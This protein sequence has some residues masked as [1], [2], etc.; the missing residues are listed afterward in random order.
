M[1]MSSGARMG[2][3]SS[4]RRLAGRSGHLHSRFRVCGAHRRIPLVRSI[5][6]DRGD[7]QQRDV[8]TPQCARYSR[9]VLP[10]FYGWSGKDNSVLCTGIVPAVILIVFLGVFALYTAK[11]LIDFKLNHPEVHNMGI[12]LIAS[13]SIAFDLHLVKGTLAIFYSDR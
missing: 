3:R 11:L 6:D 4:S 5:A 1:S 12:V 10:V 9:S 8:I 7:R 2:T 13:T